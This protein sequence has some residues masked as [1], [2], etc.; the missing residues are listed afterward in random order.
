MQVWDAPRGRGPYGITTTPDGEVY[1]ASLAGSHIARIDVET[2]AGDRDRAADPEPGRAPRVVRF[3]G[4]DLGQRVELRQAQ[5][6]TTRHGRAGGLEAAR[7]A[8][9]RLRRLRRRPRRGVAQRLRGECH[10]ALRP[11]D[12]EVRGRSR[13]TAPAPNVRQ[14][15]GRSGEVWA[16]SRAPIASSSTGASRH[17]PHGWAGR[18]AGGRPGGAPDLGRG[19][20]RPGRAGFPALLRLSLRRRGGGRAPRPE[21]SLHPGPAGGHPGGVRVLASNDR[22]GQGRPGL[23]SG[24]HRRVRRG[25]AAPGTR[26][27]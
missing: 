10:G 15:L 13:A 1:Y 24:G 4:S 23:D 3:P 17:R 19:R 22:R 14:I 12:G 16:P 20:S 5:P 8:A 18:R 11:P 9:A 6:S 26:A 21:P 27:R 25:S 2:G 7:R